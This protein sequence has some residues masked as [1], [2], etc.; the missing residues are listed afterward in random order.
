MRS[1]LHFH[2]TFMRLFGTKS[3]KSHL[4]YMSIYQCITK[5]FKV[6]NDT[7]TLFFQKK[8]FTGKRLASKVNHESTQYD[9]HHGVWDGGTEDLAVLT[10]HVA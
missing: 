5:S 8:T 1:R 7:L 6:K 2:D 4:L 9:V 10:L 3:E